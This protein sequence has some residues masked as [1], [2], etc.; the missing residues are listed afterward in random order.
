MKVF[1]SFLWVIA[2]I[3]A[4]GAVAGAAETK[5][6]RPF[7]DDQSVEYSPDKMPLLAWVFAHWQSE[8][9]AVPDPGEKFVWKK[10]AVNVAPLFALAEHQWPCQ[11]F[12]SI[13]KSDLVFFP[14]SS[15]N[16]SV[17][18][19]FEPDVDDKTLVGVMQPL[20]GG[21]IITQA[22]ERSNIL[23]IGRPVKKTKFTPPAHRHNP[24]EMST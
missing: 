24:D 2:S 7:H 12:S 11:N 21:L 8:G 22:L 1:R 23:G 15:G 14:D 20:P 5:Q 17:G 6:L 4:V 13:E 16:V 3:V 9:F 18:M 19:V 10:Y